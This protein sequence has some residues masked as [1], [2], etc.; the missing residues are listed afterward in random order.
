MGAPNTKYMLWSNFGPTSAQRLPNINRPWYNCL[1]HSYLIM[2][3]C[4]LAMP[5]T[6]PQQVIMQCETANRSWK[7]SVG[8]I[9]LRELGYTIATFMYCGLF[10]M[11]VVMAVAPILLID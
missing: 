10:T 3:P 2:G 7:L 4:Y 5:A 11:V 8:V 6:L 9:M 1:N